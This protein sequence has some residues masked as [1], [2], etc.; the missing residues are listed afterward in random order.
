VLSTCCPPTPGKA[1]M[2]IATGVTHDRGPAA[3]QAGSRQATGQEGA[4]P[5]RGPGA[6]AALMSMRWV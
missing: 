1:I 3:E 5:A 4:A 2:A 6:P